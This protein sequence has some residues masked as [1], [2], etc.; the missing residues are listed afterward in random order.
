MVIRE[1]EWSSLDRT[2]LV[3]DMDQWSPLVNAVI[4]LRVPQCFGKL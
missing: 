1:I 4:N 2:D 3:Q